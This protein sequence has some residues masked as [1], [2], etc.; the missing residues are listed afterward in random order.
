MEKLLLKGV[1]GNNVGVDV[2]GQQ[3]KDSSK[4]SQVLVDVKQGIYTADEG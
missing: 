1:R 3:T 4:A 2:G